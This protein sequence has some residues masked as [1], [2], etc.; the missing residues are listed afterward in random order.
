MTAQRFAR[1]AVM[2]EPRQDLVLREYPVPHAPPGGAVVRVTC[3]TICRS[4]LH[5]WRGLRPAPTPIIL[6]HEIVGTIAELGPGLARDVRD[7]PLAVGDRVTWTLHSACGKCRYCVEFRLP[8]KCRSLRKYGHDSCQAPPHLRGGLAEY[9]QIDAG[10]SLLKLPPGLPDFAAAPANCAAATAAAAWEAAE[11][12]SGD[13]VLIQG[14][15]ALGCYAAALAAHAGCRR[16]VVVD[17]NA[18]RLQFIRRFGATDCIDASNA[19]VDA[20]AA[21]KELT[22]GLGV[23]AAL[24]VAGDPA[25]IETGLL[26]LRTGGRYIELGCSFP[27][28]RAT[29]DMSIVLW[30]LLTV[31]GVHNYDVRHLITAVDALHEAQDRF[32][33]GDVVGA[34][35]GLEEVNA[36]LRAAHEGTAMRVAVIP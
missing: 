13:S 27:G 1:A 12:K 6:G 25:I 31:R 14:A 33:L 3:C 19:A 24:E 21:I 26:S 10:T 32:P 11:L 36:A 5:T 28:A 17:V 29:I 9:C 15:G 2:V 30:K 7:Q 22:E 34:S 16:V 20:V 23:D 35:F 4:D 18:R 8:M